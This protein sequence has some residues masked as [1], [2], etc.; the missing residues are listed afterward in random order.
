ML[1]GRSTQM[2]PRAPERQKTCIGLSVST[3]SS[4]RT[5]LPVTH[6]GMSRNVCRAV[7]MVARSLE[8]TSYCIL[9]EFL[10]PAGK[11]VL[12]ARS[13]FSGCQ[14]SNMVVY[15]IVMHD[16]SSKTFWL[17]FLRT[18]SVLDHTKESFQII[19]SSANHFGDFLCRAS[20]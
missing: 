5:R 11:F 3:S 7:A 9:A 6:V 20:T 2:P 18:L 13:I 16:R 15:L 8:K 19:I 12:T 4:G 10:Q 14:L 1:G 17:C